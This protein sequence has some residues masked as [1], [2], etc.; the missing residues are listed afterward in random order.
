MSLIYLD[1][2][3][4]TAPSEAVRQAIAPYLDTHFG[5]PSS[6]HWAGRAALDA[7]EDAREQVAGLMGARSRDLFFTGGG[8]EADNTAVLG[9]LFAGLSAG[10]NH[11][12][13]SA[14]EHPAIHDAA[15]AAERRFG[16]KV[17]HV[18]VDDQGRID[19]D[20]LRSLVNEK[21]A[22]VS[23]MLANNEIGNIYPVAEAADIAHQHGALCHTDAVQAF[24]KIPVNVQQLG[25]DLLSVSAHKLY[26]LKGCGAL[27]VRAGTRFEP[28]MLG[29]G[30]E[31]GRRGGTHNV[32][33]I[34]AFGTACAEAAAESD[35]ERIRD[36]RDRLWRR[37]TTAIPD[38]TRNGD[39][40]AC[41]P[42][43]LNV[44]IPGVDGEGLLISLDGYGLAL[45]SG[46]ACSSGS[47]KP[48]RVLTA[49]GGEP[50]RVR[51]A[52]RLSI[53][54]PTTTADI[55]TAADL[56]IADVRRLRALNEAG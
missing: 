12:V 30:Q 48:S 27:W 51:C 26:G 16:A 10:R 34:V 13:I 53:G 14:V 11:L 5:N 4:T 17:D 24:G 33:G 28:F 41:L 44:S 50:W 6:I 56:I 8:T 15:A 46:S 47:N 2:N 54:R 20:Q 23:L 40:S 32:V 39:P 31:R 38:M 29:G 22:L 52:L 19:L 25:V 42:N 1:Y 35:G 21:T 37:L 7:V 45:S 3:A 9:A 18:R 36:L 43:T 55:E 49:L